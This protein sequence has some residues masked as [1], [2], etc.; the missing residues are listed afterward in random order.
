MSDI[1]EVL[2]ELWGLGHLQRARW[3][4]PVVLFAFVRAVGT[5]RHI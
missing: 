1:T 4:F 3:S 5:P 2:A